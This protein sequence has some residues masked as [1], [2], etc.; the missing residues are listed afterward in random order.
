[1]K[2]GEELPDEKSVAF[3]RGSHCLGSVSQDFFH[4]KAP[5]IDFYVPQETLT[6][7]MFTGQKAKMHFL[8]CGDYSTTANCR[9]KSFPA[10]FDRYLEFL[11]VI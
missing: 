11:R 10:F 2:E 8:A 4:G 5:K 1:M 6:T 3:K 7:K 9:E